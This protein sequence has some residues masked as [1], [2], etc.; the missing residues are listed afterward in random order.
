[1]ADDKTTK[2]P[3]QTVTDTGP[4]KETPPEPEKTPTPPE[5]EKKTEQQAKSP[6]VSVMTSLKL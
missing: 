4:G 6:Q 3:E 1:M 5:A 2:I